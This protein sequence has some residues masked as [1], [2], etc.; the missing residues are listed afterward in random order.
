MRSLVKTVFIF[1]LIALISGD[2][3]T[4]KVESYND[5]NFI[6]DYQTIKEFEIRWSDIF[7]QE[8]NTYYVYLF[9]PFCG[10][11]LEIKNEMIYYSVLG[12]IKM[13]NI[14]ASDE[15]AF[16]TAIENT[17]GA[18]RIEDVYIIGYPSLLLIKDRVLCIN[19][20]GSQ[21]ILEIIV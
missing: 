11:C 5:D 21:R 14:I 12:Q 7:E 16:G 6:N 9:S 20:A 8:E 17:I 4:N 18:S 10:H 2:V 1:I 15:I 13:Y 19:V 3:V